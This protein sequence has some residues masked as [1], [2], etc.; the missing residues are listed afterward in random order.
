MA[1]IK[2]VCKDLFIKRMGLDSDFGSVLYDQVIFLLENIAI[3]NSNIIT[4][5][6]DISLGVW[7]D[8]NNAGLRK[9][10]ISEE[11][12]EKF[13]HLFGNKFHEKLKDFSIREQ[14]KG[15]N[16]LFQLN[17]GSLSM[18]EFEKRL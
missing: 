10:E 7:L 11:K 14:K 16:I 13:Y 3:E 5:H 6:K 12:A 8:S 18:N 9:F 2:I 17:N 1:V 4:N 15:Q